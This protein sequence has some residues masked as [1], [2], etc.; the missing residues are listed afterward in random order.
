VTADFR[1][2]LPKGGEGVG[3]DRDEPEGDHKQTSKTIKN[4][5]RMNGIG[6]QSY[7]FKGKLGLASSHT[8]GVCLNPTVI[9]DGT[10][11]IEEGEYVHPELAELARK[12]KSLL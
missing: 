9:G 8:D 6:S 2:P 10:K 12:L 1:E 4:R 5:S 3:G 11:I 7:T